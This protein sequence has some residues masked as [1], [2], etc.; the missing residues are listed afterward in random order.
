MHHLLLKPEKGK[1][2]WTYCPALLTLC[3]NFLSLNMSEWFWKT[4]CREKYLRFAT[5]HLFFNSLCIVNLFM[6]YTWNGRLFIQ[7]ISLVFRK[8][9]GKFV[10]LVFITN[11]TIT[12]VCS[13]TIKLNRDGSAKSNSDGWRI[14][15][16]KLEL[17]Q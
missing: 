5:F 13:K 12:A 3:E 6:K 1:L 14:Q 16:W 7:Y 4:F 10:F 2:H 15:I 11:D 8:N 17:E 9:N